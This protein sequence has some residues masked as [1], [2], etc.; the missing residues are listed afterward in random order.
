[1]VLGKS[2]DVLK[3]IAGGKN[4][5]QSEVV[6]NEIYLGNL[7]SL[8][9]HD[10]AWILDKNCSKPVQNLITVVLLEDQYSG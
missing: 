4:E 6:C 10:K 8:P 5:C 1:M 9:W 3:D 2:D 7:A